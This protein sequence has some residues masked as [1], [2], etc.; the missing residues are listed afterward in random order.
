MHEFKKPPQLLAQH[1]HHRVDEITPNP[2]AVQLVAQLT[3]TWLA[4]PLSK[5]PRATRMIILLAADCW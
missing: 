5:K 4:T 3:N 2:P 1:A